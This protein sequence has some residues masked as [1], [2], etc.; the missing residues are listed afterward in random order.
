MKGSPSALKALATSGTTA[1]L[2]GSRLVCWP[3]WVHRHACAPSRADRTISCYWMRSSEKPIEN[4]RW[5]A[6]RRTRVASFGLFLEFHDQRPQEVS[7]SIGSW[8]RAIAAHRFRDGGPWDTSFPQIRQSWR[9]YQIRETETIALLGL[10]VSFLLRLATVEPAP[11]TEVR[12]HLVA[13]CE[14]VRV[15]ITGTTP[16]ATALAALAESLPTPENLIDAATSLE[17]VQHADPGEYL[18][19]CLRVLAAG[20]REARSDDEGVPRAS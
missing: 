9:A 1:M 3:S 13:S 8:R 4:P 10:W 2:T 12:D 5:E 20:L 6:G 19:T 16:L 14:W 18:L 7:G 11:R 17:R 15:G